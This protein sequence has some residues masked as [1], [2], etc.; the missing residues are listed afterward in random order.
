MREFIN[1]LIKNRK[2]LIIGLCLLAIVIWWLGS[3]IS[4]LIYNKIEAQKLARQRIELDREYEQLVKQKALLEA[5][6][7]ATIEKIARTEY[8]L[9]KPGEIEFRFTEEK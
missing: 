5:Q 9:A 7:P 1:T 3:S 6:D 4:N 8:D 2:P